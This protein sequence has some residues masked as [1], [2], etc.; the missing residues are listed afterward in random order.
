MKKFLLTLFV[1]GQIWAVRAAA[2]D[3]EITYRRM[4]NAGEYVK[5]SLAN[6]S[7]NAEQFDARFI[8]KDAAG[9]TVFT[10]PWS[11]F[12]GK[13]K[14]TAMFGIDMLPFAYTDHLSCVVEVRQNGKIT[15]YSG[16]S[17]IQIEVVEIKDKS[18]V[19][20][21]TSRIAKV[22]LK[23]K[24]DDKGKMSVSVS[25]ES[26]ILKVEGLHDG[27]AVVTVPGE[28]R[29][30]FTFEVPTESAFKVRCFK[31]TLVDGKIVYSEM[32]PVPM[33][34]D[35]RRVKV[36][37]ERFGRPVWVMVSGSRLRKK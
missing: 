2:P 25:A 6:V 16:F 36:W 14:D 1:L 21:A 17:P 32:F 9:E 33:T 20:Q 3:V 30:E 19:R 27:Q 26:P 11:S 5:F 22:A 28:N 7:G 31:V 8:L 13:E 18:I 34:R 37:H 15:K 35:I 29:K 12:V 23:R 10:S 4:V 24:F